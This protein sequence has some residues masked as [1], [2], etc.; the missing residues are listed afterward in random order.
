VV[1]TQP[2]NMG[3]QASLIRTRLTIR[4]CQAGLIEGRLAERLEWG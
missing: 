2:P 1:L 4:G 3:I